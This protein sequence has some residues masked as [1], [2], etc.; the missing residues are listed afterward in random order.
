MLGGLGAFTAAVS[1][2]NSSSFWIRSAGL[3]RRSK[4]IVD[5]GF[6]LMLLP[7]REPATCPG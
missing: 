5:D 6:E 4:P 3:K 1:A 2:T 7:Q